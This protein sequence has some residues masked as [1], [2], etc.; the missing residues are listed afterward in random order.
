MMHPAAEKL[1]IIRLVEQSHLPVRGEISREQP[2]EGAK[3]VV[4]ARSLPYEPWFAASGAHFVQADLS[5]M[6]RFAP[7]L[8]KSAHAMA[9]F[10][11]WS[12]MLA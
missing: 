7:L 2:T 9:G 12:T 10:T 11:G 1:E 4:I 3:V 5:K 8:L 6:I